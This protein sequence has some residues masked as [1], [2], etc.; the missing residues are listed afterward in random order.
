MSSNDINWLGEPLPTAPTVGE[1]MVELASAIDGLTDAILV[2]GTA[3]L[4][5]KELD[6]AIAKASK[7][8]KRKDQS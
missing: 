5:K 8:T 3:R 7:H 4:S 2:V 6:K 1:A